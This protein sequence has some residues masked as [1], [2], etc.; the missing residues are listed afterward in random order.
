MSKAKAKEFALAQIVPYLNNPSSCG[1]DVAINNCSY[2][3]PEGKMC[4]AGKNMIDQ[5]KFG[6]NSIGEILSENTQDEIFKP[7][8]VDVLDT[9]EWTFLQ[10]IHDRIATLN[11]SKKDILSDVSLN[12]RIAALGL[13][14]YDELINY[15]AESMKQEIAS[16]LPMTVVVTQEVIDSA[17]VNDTLNCIGVKTLRAVIPNLEGKLIRWGRDQGFIRFTDD[18]SIY[19]KTDVDMMD[20][21]EPQKVT[22]RLL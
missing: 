1:F 18:I 11:E 5:I 10:L 8:V 4:V 9:H 21:S 6:T 15:A 16:M 19:F 7:E 17:D 3:T 12:S 14:T 20:I 22:F 13:F 2:L